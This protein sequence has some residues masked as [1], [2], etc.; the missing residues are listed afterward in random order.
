MPLLRC[1]TKIHVFPELVNGTLIRNGVLQ[2]TVKLRLYQIRVGSKSN[3]TVLIR[4][5]K[6]GHTDTDVQGRRPREDRWSDGVTSQAMPR[7]S[8]NN[9]KLEEAK[10]N[11]HLR[12]TEGTWPC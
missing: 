8:C 11:S 4:R 12:A 9:K 3:K 7:I 5:E 6:F 2:I 10:K 1:L